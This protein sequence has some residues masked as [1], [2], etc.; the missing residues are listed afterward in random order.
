MMQRLGT[1]HEDPEDVPEDGDGG[2][3]HKEG[4]QEGADGIC[5]FVFWLRRRKDGIG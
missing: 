3:E 1:F 2:A 4:E 5:H